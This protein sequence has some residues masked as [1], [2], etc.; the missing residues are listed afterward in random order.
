MRFFD[1][2]ISFLDK[3][4]HYFVGAQFLKTHTI[5]QNLN[6]A[7]YFFNRKKPLT[8]LPWNPIYATIV[9]ESRCNQRCQFCLWHS[10]DTPRPYWPVHLTFDDFQRI[11][12]ILVKNHLSHLH[13]CGTGEPLFNPEIFRMMAYARENHL[14]IS[15]MSNASSVMTPNIEKIADSGITRFFTNIDS[16][17]PDQYEELKCNARWDTAINNIKKLSE[18]RRRLKKNFIISIYCI[19]MRSNYSSYRELMKVAHEAGIDEVW[20]SYLQPFEEMNDTTS[21]KNVI[22]KSDTAIIEEIQE[23]IKIGNRLGLK[24]FPPH[25]PPHRETRLNCDTMWWKIMINLPNDKIPPDKWI[26]NISTHCFLA[27]TGEAFSFGNLFTDNFDD[28][29]NGEKIQ[30]LRYQLLTNAPEVCKKC[31]D[32]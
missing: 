19:A 13:F 1:S 5:Q 6:A 7:K 12:D 27:H 10:K 2:E 29:W 26:G 22:Q 8:I 24:I 17:F 18:A 21:L 4:S 16:G 30:S 15:M 31:P 32:L 11:V 3:C 23:A 14:S 20:F 28:I 9:T 25:Y